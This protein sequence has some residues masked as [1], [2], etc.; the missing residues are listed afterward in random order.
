MAI[1]LKHS[2]LMK[3]IHFFL[4]LV[5]AVALLAPHRVSAGED[6]DLIVVP[7]DTIDKKPVDLPEKRDGGD[8][9][10][11][12]PVDLSEKGD[13]LKKPAVPEMQKPDDLK[14]PEKSDDEKRQTSGPE[15][16]DGDDKK[17]E[18]DYDTLNGSDKNGGD[19]ESDDSRDDTV[20]EIEYKDD[21]SAQYEHVPGY[22]VAE[23]YDLY[24]EAYEVDGVGESWDYV[25]CSA[26]DHGKTC[27]W[28]KISEKECFKRGCCF[29]K[30]KCFEPKYKHGLPKRCELDSVKRIDCGQSTMQKCL[31]KGCCWKPEDD[32]PSCY[33]DS[34]VSS[35]CG[36]YFDYHKKAYDVGASKYVEPGKHIE[37]YTGICEHLSHALY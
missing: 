15:R 8:I 11:E 26:S 34:Y 30:D 19:K 22:P 35:A 13:E 6:K 23:E 33:H 25:Q 17:E 29:K 5:V 20:D 32:Q 14:L 36:T 16:R 12:K 7:D 24:E 21:E 4:L 31:A 10:Y 1:V 27:G 28:D 2:V 9:I 18:P 37:S 3:S